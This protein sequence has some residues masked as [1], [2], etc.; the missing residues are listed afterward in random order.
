MTLSTGY[1]LVSCRR[2]GPLTGTQHRR[3]PKINMRIDPYATRHGVCPL[4]L[5]TETC[6]LQ[7]CSLSS[8]NVLYITVFWPYS[9]CVCAG[10]VTAGSSIC[11][12]CCGCCSTAG[13]CCPRWNWRLCPA[14]C[15][16]STTETLT[17]RHTHTD[18]YT[19]TGEYSQIY[20]L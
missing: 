19:A 8:P 20:T 9:V 18:T 4:W 14:S 5:M 17:H 11:C 1:D 12:C 6:W 16:T 3:K 13:G 15:W 7:G 2:P 10:A